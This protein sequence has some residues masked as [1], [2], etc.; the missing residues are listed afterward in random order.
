MTRFRLP[1]S[2][3]FSF[4]G[5]VMLQ[6][7]PPHDRAVLLLARCVS[8]ADALFD[9]LAVPSGA[10]NRSDAEEHTTATVLPFPVTTTIVTCARGGASYTLRLERMWNGHLGC[11]EDDFGFVVR[12]EHKE[13]RGGVY[14]FVD[15]VFTIA[16]S[17]TSAEE[18]ARVAKIFVD[19]LGLT[20]LP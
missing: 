8:L 19:A 11:N 16:G 7:R 2:F 3:A 10:L 17:G 4:V 12:A 13:A 5:E 6:Q 20:E 1:A 9:A 14:L 15:D 18:D